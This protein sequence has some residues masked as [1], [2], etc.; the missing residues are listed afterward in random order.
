MPLCFLR[1]IV[2][3]VCGYAGYNVLEIIEEQL[4][5]FFENEEIYALM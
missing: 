2:R 4:K 3:F 1:C 5:Y